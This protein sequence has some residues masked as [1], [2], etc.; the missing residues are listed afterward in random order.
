MYEEV[1]VVSI[2]DV[3]KLP[4]GWFW[5]EP[6]DPGRRRGVGATRRRRSSD[7]SS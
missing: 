3:V 4:P 6:M 5:V 2:M 1:G 7:T